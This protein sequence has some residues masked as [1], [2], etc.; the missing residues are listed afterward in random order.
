MCADG[1]HEITLAAVGELDDLHGALD[2]GEQVAVHELDA[3][4]RT[5]GARGVDQRQQVVRADRA[6]G[7]VD[8]ELRI[9]ALDVLPRRGP[10]PALTLEH[11]QGLECGQVRARLLED[12]E[13]G[14]LDDRDLRGGVVD[15]IRDLL[16]RRGRVDRVRHRA[17]HH[18]REVGEVELGAIGEHQRDGVAAGDAQLGEPAGE[19]VDAV[20]QLAP[21]QRDLVVL[22]AHRDAVAEVLGGDAERLGDRARPERAV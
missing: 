4:G 18:H 10:L 22:R 12:A 15:H 9:G 19:R 21:G 13:V 6:P 8:V 3:L 2:G 16:R 20:A 1:S 11:D 7:G 5:R 17:E 14:L